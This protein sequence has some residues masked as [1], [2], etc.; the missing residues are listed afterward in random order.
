[1]PIILLTKSPWCSR[2]INLYIFTSVYSNN[3]GRPPEADVYIL[4]SEVLSL[5]G[6]NTFQHVLGTEPLL[7]HY[8]RQYE[9]SQ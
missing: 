5:G 9:F 8:V 7:P 6:S 4:C 1:M 2:S 3:F